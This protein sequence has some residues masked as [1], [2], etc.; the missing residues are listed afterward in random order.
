[1]TLFLIV[2][3]LAL[4]AASCAALNRIRRLKKQ[5]RKLRYKLYDYPDRYKPSKRF[6]TLLFLSKHCHWRHV[7]NTTFTFLTQT[8]SVERFHEIL[9]KSSQGANDSYLSRNIFGKYNFRN[10]ALCL[11]PIPGVATHMHQGTMTPTVEWEK[12]LDMIYPER[13][14]PNNTEDDSTC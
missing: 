9:L 5:V 1:M 4:L 13:F 10:R 8:Q 3:L 12:V 6:L 14:L 11:S 7:H 2:L